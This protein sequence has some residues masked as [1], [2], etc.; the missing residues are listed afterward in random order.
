MKVAIVGGGIAGL[1]T[2]WSLT[3]AG[4]PVS[5]F[6]QGPIPNPLSAS[7]DQHRIIR[8]G[9]GGQD[10]YART[11]LDAFAAWEDLWEDLGARH[12]RETG[13]ICI[14]RSP[15]DEGDLY[16]QGYDRMGTPYEKYGPAEA[17]DRYPFLDPHSLDFVSFNPD[18][19]ALFCQRIAKDLALWLRAHGADLLEN[20]SVEA[21]DAA[22]GGVRIAGEKR[23]FDAVVVTAGAW[24]TQLFPDLTDRLTTYRTAVVYLT[25]PADLA[26]AWT[27]APAILSVGDATVDG[28]GLPPVDGTD[29]KFGAGVVRF[30]AAADERRDE[31]PGEALRLRNYFGPPIARIEEYAVKDFK[32]CAYTF[33]ADERFMADRRGKTWIISACSGHGYK[34]GAAVG[35]HVARAVETGDEE[36]LVHW[37]EAR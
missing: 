7:G 16:T 30:P 23:F 36:R 17:A 14:S 6:E 25:P 34:F 12:F 18:G 1:C 5:V 2:A 3:K 33:T 11:V 21:V 4:H 13:V 10:G 37:L 32:T 15:G 8:R 24:A 35:Q 22:G 19:G 29:L 26:E 20:A 27:S 9:Y 28:Y 31:E